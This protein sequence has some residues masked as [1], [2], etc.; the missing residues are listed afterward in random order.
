MF[1]SLRSDIV[2]RLTDAEFRGVER[3]TWIQK[4]TC[5]ECHK[6]EA[7]AHADSP[8]LVF[9]GRLN[10]CG[11]R[12]HV[13]D[14]FPEIFD[15]WTERYQPPADAKPNPTAVANG[16]LR[17]GR[18]F[19]LTLIHGTYTQE[20]FFSQ[21]W[22]IGTTTVRFTLPS[23]ATWE[24]LLDRPHRFGQKAHF[25][26]QYR[27]DAWSLYDDTDLAQA[28]EVWIV[29]GIFDAI[30]LAHVGIRAIS[31]MSCANFPGDR[32]A[33][34]QQAAT[35]ASTKRPALI[36]ALDNNPAGRDA[37]E[38]HIERAAALGWT[39]DGA[40]PPGGRDWNK[41]WQ[42]GE[43]ED[44]DVERYRY[45][46]ALL[47]APTPTAKAALIYRRT[48]R[49]DFWFEH[50]RRVY[51]FELNPDDL[52]KALES[53]TG[54]SDADERQPT[55]AEMD[56]AIRQAGKI[57]RICNAHPTALY[58]QAN[59]D[60]DE[61]W[62]YCRVDS[63]DGTSVQNTF[64]GGQLAAASEFKKRLMGISAGAIWSG[65]SMQ[66]DR[67][68][69]DQFQR[70]KTVETVDFVG[71]AREHGAYLLGD[72]AISRGRVYRK[73][74][75]DYFDFGRTR[76][77]SLSHSPEL[78]INPDLEA[79]D[80]S[81]VANLVGAFG[82]DGV[83]ALAFWLGSMVAEQIRE[84][85]KS[86]PFL[87]IVGEAGAGKSTLIEFL[88][89]LAGR[90]DYEGFDPTK[91]SLPARSRN[92]AQ[93]ANLPVVLNESDRELDGGARGRQFDW[94]ELKTAYNGRNIRA[95]G[96]KNAGNETYEP[97]FRGAIVI[98]QNAE[99]QASEAIQSRICHLRFTKSRQTRATKELAEALER[100]DVDAVSGFSVRAATHA[101]QIVD[102][103]SER[104][105]SYEAYLLEDDHIRARRIAKN[106]AQLLA[107]VD[108]LGPD[109]LNLIDESTVGDGNERVI[110][111]ARER[112]T[113]INADHPMVEEFWEAYDFIES[114]YEGSSLNHYGSNEDHGRIA[115]NL[116]EFE[117][118]CG[119]HR[120]HSVPPVKEM[121]RY[122]R[123]SRSRPFVDSNISV[124]SRLRDNAATVRCWVFTDS[125]NRQ[126]KP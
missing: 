24:R 118:M 89:K 5:P 44:A 116:K 9:C 96:V 126:Q 57:S 81:W 46:G 45:Y 85:H 40:Q 93:V 105:A 110:Q 23:G 77:K 99:V 56:E 60:T 22:G 124:R 8:W 113:A 88:W 27:G 64:N 120:L 42:H 49:R 47:L 69:T 16:Y 54:D 4:I 43:L 71:Y 70:I 80:T 95:R 68:L 59:A 33:R 101:Q 35:D 84:A 114:M 91:A 62:Y 66:L 58:Y 39:N 28:G 115:I 53:V 123:G 92:F 106:H 94:D 55:A 18:G 119:Q 74:G 11:V 83:A 25:R 31:A 102:L 79:F 103:V 12:S 121:K 17:D 65:S 75:E 7:Y 6:R 41:L 125:P 72:I 19:D 76:L 26:G 107:L 1:A 87:E 61:A 90:V 13:T 117:A 51:W 78:H 38:R 34:L 73:T 109:G 86:F 3:H 37:M 67:L 50:S 32:L 15:S 100:A 36:W 14:L 98:S 10:N 112:Q 30:A 20:S 111:M 2:A 52:N 29:E 104:V 108:A 82:A 122:L 21:Q 48:P 97:P 63:P